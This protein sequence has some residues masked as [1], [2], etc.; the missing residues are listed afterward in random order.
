MTIFI[1]KF[2]AHVQH[3]KF[4]DYK[5]CIATIIRIYLTLRCL[6]EGRIFQPLGKDVPTADFGGA[7][8]SANWSHEDEVHYSTVH[9]FSP[10]IN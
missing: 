6:P 5:K 2:M 1:L 9:L 4:S 7:I 8:L 10:K 3:T